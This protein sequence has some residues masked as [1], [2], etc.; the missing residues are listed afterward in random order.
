MIKLSE[1]YEFLREDEITPDQFDLGFLIITL[2]DNIYN[3]LYV[4]SKY[5]IVT[6]PDEN[7]DNDNILQVIWGSRDRLYFDFEIRKNK[8]IHWM[9]IDFSHSDEP[10]ES[11]ILDYTNV[12]IPPNLTALIKAAY[13]GKNERA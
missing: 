7:N 12:V 5:E 2:V 4:S 11:G 9:A 6:K 8:E 3:K 10:M 13:G 1:W